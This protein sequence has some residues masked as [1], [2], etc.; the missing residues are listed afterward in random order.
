[1]AE[2]SC[3]C[4]CG[5]IRLLFACSGAADVGALADQAARK[6]SKEGVGSMVC[7]AGI[8]GGISGMIESAKAA[9]KVLVID[10]CPV[11]CGK[12]A[13]EK[14]GISNFDFIRVT[15]MGLT[16][17]KSPVDDK[18]IEKVAQKGREILSQKSSCCG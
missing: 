1:M 18:N 16:K 6:L 10:G 15:D 4:G 13:M 2:S 3:G 11:D 8:G 9:S 17:G 14:A 12:K 5:E 7:L